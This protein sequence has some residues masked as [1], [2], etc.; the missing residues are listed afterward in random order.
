M[1]E[2]RTFFNLLA[3]AGLL[4]FSGTANAQHKHDAETEH[5]ADAKTTNALSDAEMLAIHV[6]GICPVTGEPLGSMGQPVKVQMG[7]QFAYLCCKGCIGKQ[8]S[9]EHWQTIQARMAKAQGTCPIMGKPVT[10][11]MKS[12]V[13]E[14][15]QIFVC[16][17]PCIEKIQADPAAALAKVRE[18]YTAFVTAE[19]SAHSE[20]YRMMAQAICPV[21]GGKLGSMGDP[22]KTKMGEQDVYLCCKGCVGK[23]ASADHWKTIQ[24][25][26]I[27]AQGNCPVMDEEL[28]ADTE[29]VIID[30]RQ[31]FV[32]C[33]PCIEKIKADPATYL[34]KVDAMYARTMGAMHQDHA[35]HEHAEG[36][37]N[38]VHKHDK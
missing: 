7:E 23:Q 10:A 21:S 16:C 18:S 27:K 25:N 1:I 38:E 19:N 14:G 22:I 26:L 28:P 11:E 24:T 20:H 15:Q 17:P 30:G 33:K 8:A 13:I 4:A 37:S 34:A 29:S 35:G 36:Q 9:A 3:I 32:C 31:I 12:T 2:M 6:Q 5:P